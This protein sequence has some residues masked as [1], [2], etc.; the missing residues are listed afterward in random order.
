MEQPKRGSVLGDLLFCF[1]KELQKAKIKHVWPTFGTITHLSPRNKLLTPYL[2]FWKFTEFSIKI[3]HRTH[4]AACRVHQG[5]TKPWLLPKFAHILVALIC[6][7]NSIHRQL[8]IE[9]FI[10]HHTGN[11]W[12]NLAAA[13]CLISILSSLVTPVTVTVEGTF[14]VSRIGEAALLR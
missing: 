14:Y 13:L 4:D 10:K 9:A 6:A 5:H 12:L 11:V 8:F 1:R 2:H 3:N 7:N